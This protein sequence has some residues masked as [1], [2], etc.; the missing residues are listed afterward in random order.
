[1]TGL[2]Q[3]LGVIKTVWKDEEK[4]TTERMTGIGLLH[5]QELQQDESLTLDEITSEPAPAEMADA[6]PD[7]QV[8]SLSMTRTW[9]DGCNK[10]MSIPP[11]EFK[12]SQRSASLDGIEYCAHE[13]EKTRSELIGMGFETDLV[14]G[15]SSDKRR[16]TDRQDGRF[17]DEDRREDTARKK[18]SDILTLVEEYPLID[19][20]E[21]GRLERLQVFRVG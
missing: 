1:K 16:D 10:V 13:C 20:D 6:F 9:D 12:V 2:I 19:V 14:M 4:S 3:R 17:Q 15:L 11:E 21:D 7:G 18:A 8:Y 5:L